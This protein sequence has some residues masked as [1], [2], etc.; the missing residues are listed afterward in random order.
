MK[1]SASCGGI[2]SVVGNDYT[3]KDARGKCPGDS[4]PF[5]DRDTGE[6]R[7]AYKERNEAKSPLLHPGK[8]EFQADVSIHAD[9]VRHAEWYSIFQIHNGVR[10][11]IPPSMFTVCQYGRW[12]IDG[13]DTYVTPKLEFALKVNLEIKE[14]FITVDYYVDEEYL[15]SSRTYELAQ[16]FIKFGLYRMNE[17]CSAT[18]IYKN[19]RVN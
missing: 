5:Y 15:G 16:P 9:K 4:D 2:H 18:Q 6:Q 10:D 17:Y 8:Y 12:H 1:F 7:W 14:N 11:G 3:F 19:V 13:R